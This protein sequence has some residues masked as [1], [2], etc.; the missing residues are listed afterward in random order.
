MATTTIQVTDDVLETLK[1]LRE[2]ENV[3]SYNAVLKRVLA[4][5][6][7][8]TIAGILGKEFSMKSILKDLRDKDE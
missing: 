4:K 1:Q 8:K 2:E 6:R 3:P 7:S 5:Q